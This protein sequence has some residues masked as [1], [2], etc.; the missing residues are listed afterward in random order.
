M[1]PCEANHSSSSSSAAAAGEM[2]F[3]TTNLKSIYKKLLL[4]WLAVWVGI[5]LSIYVCSACQIWSNFGP[6]INSI[7]KSK[8]NR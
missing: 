7:V 6:M 8:L 5:G 3:D 2:K 4:G 1:P